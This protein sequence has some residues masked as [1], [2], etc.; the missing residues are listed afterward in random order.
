MRN[1][2]RLQFNNIIIDH[3]HYLYTHY[4]NMLSMGMQTQITMADGGKAPARIKA[5]RP[6]LASGRRN[7][8]C[9]IFKFSALVR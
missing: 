9:S 1:L 7:T 8:I 2:L 3:T 4:I 5:S 6:Y